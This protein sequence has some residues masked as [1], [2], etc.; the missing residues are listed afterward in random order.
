M[1]CAGDVSSA[2]VLMRVEAEPIHLP[3]G[4]VTFMFT[5][6]EGST[7]LLADAGDAAYSELL[8]AHHALMR[9]AITSGGGVE[10][11]T[12]GD[13]FFAVFVDPLAAVVTASLIQRRLSD[14]AWKVSMPMRVR[15]G[16]HT[17]HGVL[18][19]DDYVGV[20][21]NRA[22]RISDAGD[23]GQVVVSE[24]TANLVE[25]RLPT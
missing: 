4:T 14:P 3:T 9:E 5:D 8:E 11:G 23:G 6:I 22:H 17:G 19:A 18:G 25:G 1:C 15:I 24:E 16:V 21:V 7:R 20:D 2:V 13:S 10:V 12:E